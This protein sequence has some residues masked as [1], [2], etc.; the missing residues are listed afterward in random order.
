[1]NDVTNK[2]IGI[3]KH[4]KISKGLNLPITGEPEISL[5][6]ASSVTEVALLG[7]DYIGMKPTMLVT[8]GDRVK[9]GQPLFE[10]KKIEGVTYNS[11]A[12]G[13]VKAVNRGEK[14]SFQ[15]I[16]ISVEG[17]D[18]VTFETFSQDA[19][20][21]LSKEKIQDQLLKS[22]QWV[23]LRS[24]PYG[25]VA[26][27]SD[28]PHSLFITA[29]DTN[30][31]APPASMIIGQRFNEFS[32]GCK[33]LSKLTDGTTYVCVGRKEGLVLK[34]REMSGLT[35]AQFDGPHPAGLAGTHIHFLDPVSENK[36]VW[37]IGY[38]DV[39]A[40]GS[41]FLTGRISVERIISLAGPQ[42]EKPRLLRTRLGANLS[43]LTNGE[44]KEG[45]NR[46][47]S[48]SVLNGHIAAEPNQFLGK[49][50]NQVSVIKEGRERVLLGWQR[51]G[52][53]KFSVKRTFVAKLLPGIK[54][55]FTSSREGSERALVPV[56]MYESVMPLDIL[57]TPLLKA[58]LMHN[59]EMSANLGALELVE[60]D[61][62]L[63]TFVCPGKQ[64]YDRYLRE[65][66]NLIEKGE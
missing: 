38:Q 54:F 63:C 59:T 49:Y 43:Q 18:E 29:I 61:L 64:N 44:L 9:L 47:I 1:M 28:K 12:A 7:S 2:S 34:D 15:S 33:V 66:L 25:K 19:L 30:P 31:L 37:Q 60:E 8:E 45:E 6:D 11:P 27:P 10:D 20:G 26:N 36:T 58:L 22:G 32:A 57:P 16:V 35:L 62:A 50:H 4:I 13:V 17:N 3:S 5:S 46:V 52:L 42:V 24:R 55:P 51:P 53:D 48:G 40:I 14:R 23:S 41:L 21:G 39:I 56:G 65:T